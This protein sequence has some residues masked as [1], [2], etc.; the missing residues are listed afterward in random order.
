MRT[1]IC[2]TGT[3][4]AKKCD[5]LRQYHQSA[6]GWD[7]D[8]SDL[9]E[10]IRQYVAGLDFASERDRIDVSAELHSL[11]RL[12]VGKDDTVVLLATDTADGRACAEAVADTLAEHF[13]L[14]RGNIQIHRIK[15]LQ[16]RDAA[17]FRNCGLANFIE[18]VMGYVNDPQHRYGGE[19]ILNP[20]GGYKGVV[21]FLSVLGMLFSLRTVY[22]FEFSSALISLPPLPVTFNITLFERALPALLWVKEHSL[23]PEQQ[24]YERILHF[25]S[26]EQDLFAGFVEKEEGMVTLSTLSF[27][28]LKIEES[29]SATARI[30]PSVQKQLKQVDAVARVAME[31]LLA[32]SQS[33]L[34]RSIHV[35][36]FKGT[37]LDVFK[38]G[39]T[40]ERIAGIIREG[41][42]YV[43]ELYLDHDLYERDLYGKQ[44]TQYDLDRFV[45]WEQQTSVVELEKQWENEL[46]K[47][48]AELEAELREAMQLA[49]KTIGD[50]LGKLKKTVKTKDALF[51]QERNKVANLQKEVGQLKRSLAQYKRAEGKR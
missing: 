5:C 39:N 42:F 21:P 50:Q 37:D 46:Q 10:Q 22:V 6:K 16:V 23:V 14:P 45:V 31:R 7:D 2:T 43:C 40:P 19:I 27:V 4:I 26:N 33:P 35:H 24:F 25:E 28:L 12:G 11:Y 15:G 34:W 30:A 20:T 47:R 41:Q 48:V 49:G 36:P 1:I 18:A 17:L 29:G 8:Y 38:P 44:R 9:Q 32:R 51:V 3:S 13:G